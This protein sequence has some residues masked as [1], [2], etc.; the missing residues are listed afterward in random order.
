[1][2]KKTPNDT[3]NSS[4]KPKSWHPQ[5]E[6]ILKNWSEVGS[7]YRY[8]HDKSFNKY[9]RCNMCFSLPVIILN[10]LLEWLI[11]LNLVSQLICDPLL[12][13]LLVR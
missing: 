1:M 8:L 4:K 10:I 6:K 11:L 13:L 3:D 12:A 5:Q 7:S 2:D 9:E